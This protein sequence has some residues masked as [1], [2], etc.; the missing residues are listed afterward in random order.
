LAFRLRE[1]FKAALMSNAAALIAAHNHP[2]GN[3]TP[4]APDIALTEQ[5]VD[6]G[7]CW[8]SPCSITS[9]SDTDTA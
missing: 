9:S 8:G 7:V 2:S 6:A 5:L 3:P 4:S 1:V